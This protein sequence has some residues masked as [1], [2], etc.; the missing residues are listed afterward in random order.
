MSLTSYRFS[1]WRCELKFQASVIQIAYTRYC[2]YYKIRRSLFLFVNKV[3]KPM[4]SC[5]ANKVTK[6]GSS[7]SAIKSEGLF[8]FSVNEQCIVGEERKMGYFKIEQ[9][10]NESMK[11]KIRDNKC[12]L[13]NITSFCSNKRLWNEDNRACKRKLFE[14]IF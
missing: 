6:A 5:S 14:N 12:G 11:T 8:F 2:Y 3:M 4:Y 10:W 9:L 1:N 13:I 7:L